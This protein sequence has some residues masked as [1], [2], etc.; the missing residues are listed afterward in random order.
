[1]EPIFKCI[2]DSIDTP[3]YKITVDD[4]INEDLRR[5]DVE[6]GISNNKY[7]PTLTRKIFDELEGDFEARTRKIAKIYGLEDE[8]EQYLI[9]NGPY[10]SHND[11]DSIMQRAF[12]SKVEGDKSL[13]I[14]VEDKR[15][16]KEISGLNVTYELIKT[17]VKYLGKSIVYGGLPAEIQKKLAGENI[18]DPIY[19]TRIHSSI[20]FLIGTSI[21]IYSVIGIDH[22]NGTI[23]RGIPSILF[24]GINFLR[25]ISTFE[26]NSEPIGSTIITP[27]YYLINGVKTMHQ[28]KRKE[29]ESG[30]RIET[31]I[32]EIQQLPSPT[33]EQV[34]VLIEDERIKTK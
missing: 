11:L 12:C 10:R 4:S 21:A 29:L 28:N 2:E 22:I 14:L 5:R 32:E 27:L 17:A 26:E 15:Y 8:V 13:E 30:L 16:N 31:R 34:S 23:F 1:M 33:E 9:N 7:D 24:G 6:I 25:F 19:Y 18:K 3:D 20:E